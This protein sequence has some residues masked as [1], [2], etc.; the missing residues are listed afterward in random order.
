MKP[1]ELALTP[2]RNR[3][4]NEVTGMVL[5]VAASLLFLALASYRPTDPSFNTVGTAGRQVHNWTG[6]VGAFLSDILLQLE[7][8]AAFMIPLLLGVLGWTWLRSRPAGSPAAKVSG[9]LLYLVFAPAIFGLI[10]GHLRWMHAL[11]LEGLTGRLVVDTLVHYLNFPGAAIVIVSMV[12][13]A[14]YLSTTFSFG[15]AQQWMAIRFA[16]ALAWRDRIRNWRT[17]WA[18]ARAE[19]NA[20]KRAAQRDIKAN[21]SAEKAAARQ[22]QR[23]EDEER[24]PPSRRAAF[25]DASAEE[26]HTPS[27]WNQMPRTNIP[28]RDLDPEP[29]DPEAEEVATVVPPP[30]VAKAPRAAPQPTAHGAPQNISVKGRADAEARPV[31]LAP[32]AVSGFRLPPSTLLHRSDESQ[33][34]REDDLRNQARVLV[35]KCAEFDVRGQVVQINPGPVVTTFEFRPEAGVKYSRVTGLAED[36][37]LAMR[38]ESILIERMAGKSTVG[39][40]VPN[41][42]RETIWLRDVIEAENFTQT[43]SKLTLA[44]GKDINGRLVTADLAT[45]P[46]VLIAGSTGSGKSV[47]INAMIM[48]VLYK[49][50]PQQVR[51]IL[52]DP[53]RVELG[54]YEGIPHLFTPII[55]EPKLA[56]NALR[57]AVREMER[58]LKLLASRSVRNIDQYNKLFDNQTPSL[59]E[60]PEAEQPLPHMIIIIDELADLMMLDKANVEEAITRLAQMARAVGIHLVLATQRP[61]VDVI[62]G[63]IKANVPTRIS[64]RLA[65]KVDSRTILDSNGAE[66]LLGRG[67]ML[68][69]P[70]G[71]SRLQRLHAPFVTEKEIAAVVEFWKNQGEAEYVQGFLESPRDEKGRDLDA[72]PEDGDGND[73]LFEDAVRLVLE[74]GKASTSL[75]QRRLRIGYGRAAHLIDMMERDGIVGPADGSKPREIL[76]PPD[77]LNQVEPALR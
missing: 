45:M 37:C 41:H 2:T 24:I 33:V 57:N 8:V 74:F 19:K 68:F 40:Q 11:P 23:V 30:A 18:R 61:S 47:A 1:L 5:L 10:P 16:F 75:L 26:A 64:F 54:M 32:R 59:F 36:L 76:K 65:T 53:K 67:D 38:A 28:D 48:S 72:E 22:A 15:T 35:E 62:T 12:V 9:V 73:E 7:G 31:T 17:S 69:L 70:P 63:L 20:L 3:R 43:K 39:I 56:A 34:V 27:L 29:L 44:M 52:V 6:L 14:L 21:K 58:R 66:A 55:T 25:S 4:L 42:D 60:D 13:I 49:A 71:T 50:T 51:L 46:H 77:W